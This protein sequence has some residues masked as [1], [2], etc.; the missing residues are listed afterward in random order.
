[1][2]CG[3]VLVSHSRP[4]AEAT[5][6]LAGAMSPGGAVPLEIA[7]GVSDT[8]IG[9]NAMDVVDAIEKV[10]AAAE[11]V[12]IFTD[13]GSAI[14]SA[15][16][17]LDF[18]D[19]EL[20]ARCTL[21]RAPFV[22]GVV[23]AA[24]KASLGRE[25]AAV[26]K[27]ACRGL[28]PKEALIKDADVTPRV[29]IDVDVTGSASE[30]VDPFDPQLPRLEFLLDVTPVDYRRAPTVIEEIERLEIAQARSAA[31]LRRIGERVGEARSLMEHLAR[32]VEDDRVTALVREEIL[33]CG[34]A[35]GAVENR[36]EA[37][38][39]TISDD[40][41]ES[42][43]EQA[44][45]VRVLARLILGC[46]LGTP[47][48]GVADARDIHTPCVLVLPELDVVTAALLRPSSVTGV[49][50]VS[51]GCRGHGIDIATALGVPVRR[52]DRS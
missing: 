43:R 11:E 34:N 36:L 12:L 8:E 24:A 15:Q 13:L 5:A 30:V 44:G 20:A 21:S 22:E 33:A 31:L 39:G 9:T 26:E 6:E 25:L 50:V 29:E 27:E 45:D 32:V 52:L 19:P 47:L 28:A 18:V 14:L 37:I 38:T 23:G 7:A 4:L 49:E 46:L 17:A 2:S 40:E 3:F 51:G 1:M 41:V 10:G 48:A 35:F 42:L 16:T